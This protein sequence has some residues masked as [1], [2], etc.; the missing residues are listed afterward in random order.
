VAEYPLAIRAR[1]AVTPAG[2]RPVTVAVREGKI[3]AVARFADAPDAA[4]AVELP[5]TEI[6]LP[7]L[8]DT[9][10]HVNE[11]GRTDWEGFAAATF[12]VAPARLYHRH[13][14]TP[15][16]G[17]TLTGVVRRTWLRGEPADPGSSS[18]GCA[19]PPPGGRL[20]SRGGHP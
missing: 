20:L 1:R 3:A 14:V 11:P 12:R 19:G 4:R 15:Y 18:N 9:H 6:L 2:V 16:A 5:D 7:G 17:R 13:P 10:V 8:V